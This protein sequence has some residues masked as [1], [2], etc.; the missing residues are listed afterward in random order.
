MTT[1]KNC[2]Q[3]ANYGDSVCSKCGLPMTPAPP[4]PPP[5][6]YGA[7][8]PYSNNTPGYNN[9]GAYPQKTKSKVAAGLLA[10]LVGLGIYNFYL[11]KTGKALL[12]LFGGLIGYGLLMYDV[13]VYTIEIMEWIPG[14]PEPTFF[15]P[16]YIIGLL[17][18]SAVGLWQ[19]I[20]GIMILCGKITVDGQGNPIV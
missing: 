13:A 17:L 3:S 1:C 5:N 6:N 19:F 20:E 2:G 12:Q 8:Q 10:L 16:A 9:P 11:K 4:P 18:V 14:T 15:T 7:P